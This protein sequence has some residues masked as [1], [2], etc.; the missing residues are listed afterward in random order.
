VYRLAS[1]VVHDS[2]GSA[3]NGFL[4][5]PEAAETKRNAF[6]DVSSA[7]TKASTPRFDGC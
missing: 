4:E 2:I 5:Y 3:L 7:V 1:D 6:I